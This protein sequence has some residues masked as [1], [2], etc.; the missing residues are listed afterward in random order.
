MNPLLTAEIYAFAG[1]VPEDLHV[2]DGRTGECEV[3]VLVDADLYLA[4][5]KPAA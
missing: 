4:S 1:T 3:H 5:I 2:D